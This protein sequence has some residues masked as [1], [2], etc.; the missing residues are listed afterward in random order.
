M[1][2]LVGNVALEMVGPAE[3]PRAQVAHVL[4]LPRVRHLVTFQVHL[5]IEST[6][7]NIALVNLVSLILNG[8]GFGVELQPAQNSNMMQSKI[9]EHT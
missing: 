5:H 2:M 9:E 8:V 3:R 4:A 7:A 6:L 1:A